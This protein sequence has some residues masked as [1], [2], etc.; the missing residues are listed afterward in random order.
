MTLP[1][2][3]SLE[4]IVVKLAVIAAGV[5]LLFS[6]I[7][8]YTIL[9]ISLRTFFSFFF[10]YFLGTSFIRLWEKLSP[11]PPEEASYG[12]KIDI[13]LGDISALENS[14]EGRSIDQEDIATGTGTYG[15]I[16]PG[17]INIDMQNGLADAKNK[18]E[19]VRRMGL[20]E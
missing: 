17:Q 15:R 3:Q 1:E 13:I 18:A 7:N 6:V 14:L 11:Q 20:E 10:I 19:I 2:K 8:G 9:M 16:I 4:S 12:S 5:V